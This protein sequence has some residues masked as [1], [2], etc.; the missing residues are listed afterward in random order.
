MFEKV[1][2]TT[3]HVTFFEVLGV[4]SVFVLF[5]FYDDRDGDK[6]VDTRVFWLGHKNN[7]KVINSSRK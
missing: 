7:M 1:L 6:G 3:L 5:F 4:N 2:N